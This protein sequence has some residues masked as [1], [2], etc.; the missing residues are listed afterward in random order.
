MEFVCPTCGK[1]MER[2]LLHII[3]HTEGHI[4]QEIKKKHPSWE[5]DNGVCEKCYEHYKK[6]MGQE[7]RK[8]K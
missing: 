2:E 4:V 8:R 5:D 7:R 6:E 1:V 3:D